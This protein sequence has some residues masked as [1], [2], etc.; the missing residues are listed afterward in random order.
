MKNIKYL[1]LIFGITAFVGCNEPE[2]VLKDTNIE[3]EE[4]VTLPELVSG[5]VDFSTYVSVGNSL[6]AGFTDNA[7][8]KA[9]QENSFPNILAQKFKMLGGG[10]F[11]QPLT[12]DNIGGLVIGGNTIINPE[13]GEQLFKPRLVTTGGAPQDLADVIGPITPTTD[14]AINNPTGPFNN[15]GVPG[16]RSFHM[17]APGYGNIANFPVAANP[18]FIRM[19]GTTPNASILE[20]AMAQSPTFFTLWAGNNDVLGYATSGGD[21]SS[22]ISDK[23]TFD[24]AIS[25]LI[26]SL[27][28][29]GAKGVVANIPY[30]TNIPHFT[31]VP[32][33]A[34]NPND[35][36]T[37]PQFKAQIPLLNT[38]Y[39][40]LN[41]IFAVLDPSRTIVF[42]ETEASG[43]VIYDETLDDLSNEIAGALGNNP[44]F[45]LFVQSLGLETDDAPLVA[46]LLG[47]AYGQARQANENDLL[48]LPSNSIIGEVNEFSYQSLLALDLPPVLAAQFSIEGITLPLIDKWVLLPSEQAE[49]KTATDDFNTTIQTAAN[50]A[51]LAYVNTNALLTNLATSGITSNNFTL[52]SNLVTGGAFS[53][54]GVHLT[55]RGYAMIANEF[56]KAIDAT[57]GTN[58]EASGNLVN[59]GNY[60]TNYSPLLQ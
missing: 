60:P 2:D 37:G 18:Y 35:E 19:T 27:T 43:V 33:N 46:L 44:A 23:A 39:G 57:Y 17:I 21:G 47:N 11:T 51:G 42:S 20:L 48:V 49:I 36:E 32:Y 6:T 14:I 5:S 13:T 15:M 58:F 30:V 31:T 1:T 59:I 12:N 52:T 9:S 40:T 8:F 16:A 34:L 10:N 4:V 54:D 22:P 28:S 7:L 26:T 38:V 50:N 53:L 25:T 45:P 41:Q 56:M 29:G 3:P 24:F 55:S